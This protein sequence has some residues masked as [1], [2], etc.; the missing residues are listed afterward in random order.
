MVEGARGQVD[1]VLRV[2]EELDQRLLEAEFRGEDPGG[3]PNPTR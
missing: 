1:I 3:V 2:A